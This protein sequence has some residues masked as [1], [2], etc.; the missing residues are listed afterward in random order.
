MFRPPLPRRLVRLARTPAATAPR[1]QI[2]PHPGPCRLISSHGR[3]RLLLH[4][5]SL[6]HLAAVWLSRRAHGSTGARGPPAAAWPS[7]RACAGARVC[8]C[9]IV[10]L[11][12]G[13]PSRCT[14]P[15]VS[16]ASVAMETETKLDMETGGQGLRGVGGRDRRGCSDE[17]AATTAP[18]DM[19]ARTAGGHHRSHAGAG[20]LG[21]HRAGYLQKTL[22]G[23]VMS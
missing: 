15:D 10:P 23:G 7:L 8:T 13:I 5:R 2:R 4:C 3:A 22:V 6:S 14:A 21:C 12:C 9:S 11:P 18:L 19:V 20:G 1:A 17:P 16:H